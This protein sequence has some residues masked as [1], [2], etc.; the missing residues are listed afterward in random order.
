VV[1]ACALLSFDGVSLFVVSF[2]VFPIADALFRQ[3]NIPHRLIPATIALEAFTFTM[4][5]LPGTPAIQNAIPMP[6]FGITLLAVPGI[7]ILAALVTLLAICGGHTEAELRAHRYGDRDRTALWPDRCDRPRHPVRRL[8]RFLVGRAERARG[9][10]Y[11][12]GASSLAAFAPTF[13]GNDR[14]S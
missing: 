11:R 3:A 6:H 10:T 5:A 4:T 2:A 13:W 7:G 1:L 12:I 8:L 9:T 14:A